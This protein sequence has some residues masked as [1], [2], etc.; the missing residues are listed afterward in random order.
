ME[1]TP[2]G[3][4]EVSNVSNVIAWYG[5]YT[6]LGPGYYNVTFLIS[7]SSS[8][9]S[10]RAVL[11][12]TSDY[13]KSY[14][15]TLGITGPYV[16]AGRWVEVS[17]PVYV[18]STQDGVEFRCAVQGWSG[19][20]Y[21]SR[22]LVTWEGQAP[23]SISTV[24]PATQ[25]WTANGSSYSDGMIVATNA[26]R[27]MWYGPYATLY[28]GSYNVTFWIDGNMSTSLEV[29]LQV[30]SNYGNTVLAQGA[31]YGRNVHGWTPV[32]LQVNLDSTQQGAEFRGWAIGLDGTV[33][34]GNVTVEGHVR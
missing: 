14:L 16:G 7:S 8:S 24:Y 20:L 3:A 11:Q 34:L 26:S 32:T 19:S 31:V 6:T 17:V 30:T 4:I 23:S 28:P 18:S 13:G 29:L 2:S 25:M 9:P 33:E 1:L 15:V 27:I 10:D 5:P 21:L 12:V 22:I